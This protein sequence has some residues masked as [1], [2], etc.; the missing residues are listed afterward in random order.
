MCLSTPLVWC[1]TFSNLASV[2]DRVPHA[3]HCEGHKVPRAHRILTS[4]LLLHSSSPAHSEAILSHT[5]PRF[6]HLHVCFLLVCLWRLTVMFL[7]YVFCH[8]AVLFHAQTNFSVV[9][10]EVGLVSHVQTR[11]PPML[12][13]IISGK[14]GSF[15][16]CFSNCPCHLCCPRTL[17]CR[18]PTRYTQTA[19]RRRV[20]GPSHGSPHAFGYHFSDKKRK[21]QFSKSSLPS[22][23]S[24][25]NILST[26]RPPSS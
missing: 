4:F 15:I 2:C 25:Y 7:A 3:H 17:S 24:S 14:K 10:T 5:H 11:C 1:D 9:D 26:F 8:H 16:F 18:D 6:C 22:S 20:T 12:S 23:L 13:A 21:L 19:Q